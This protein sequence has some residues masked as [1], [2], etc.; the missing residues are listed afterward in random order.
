MP[1]GLPKGT[2]GAVATV[3]LKLPLL[4]HIYAWMGCVP[5]D[6]LTVHQLLQTISVGIVPE[7]LDCLVL[8][9]QSFNCHARAAVLAFISTLTHARCRDCFA[10]MPSCM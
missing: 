6:F 9:S 1:V 8:L 2:R 10:C 4:R 3:L 5:A 7:V